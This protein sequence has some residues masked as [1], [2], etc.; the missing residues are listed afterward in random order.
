MVWVGP[1]DR[2][3]RPVG[4]S[5][6]R[7]AASGTSG[8]TTDPL[9]SRTIQL[10]GRT[11][12]AS[13]SV[14]PRLSQNAL[15]VRIQTL[16]PR[17]TSWSVEPLKLAVPISPPDLLA[18]QLIEYRVPVWVNL[19][20]TFTTGAEVRLVAASFTSWSALFPD[21]NRPAFEKRTRR[22]TKPS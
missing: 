3:V 1:L 14:R 17:E 15:S 13:A 19:A 4:S 22:R 16:S 21:G 11:F 12:C 18:C 8:A 10:P 9:L 6:R 5:R 7:L 20:S 2:S